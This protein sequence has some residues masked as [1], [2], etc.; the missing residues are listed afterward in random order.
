MTIKSAEESLDKAR[1]YLHKMLGHSFF[2]IETISNK[3]EGNLWIV[4]LRLIHLLKKEYTLYNIHINPETGEIVNV[5]NVRE[6]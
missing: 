2:E 4:R 6:Q 3:K 5:E 1:E